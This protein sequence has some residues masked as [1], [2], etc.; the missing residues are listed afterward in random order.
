MTYDMISMRQICCQGLV[1]TVSVLEDQVLIQEPSHA[2]P[3]D[4]DLKEAPCSDGW[5]GN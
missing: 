5:D 2:A 4:S 3:A 1:C